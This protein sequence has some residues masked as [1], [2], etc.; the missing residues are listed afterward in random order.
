MNKITSIKIKQNDGTFSDQMPIS[1]L[2]ENI[3]WD[4]THSIIDAIGAVDIN[5][6]GPLQDQ[7]NNK[8]NTTDLSNYVN[9]QLAEDVA[10]W[11]NANVNPVGS[12]V[13]VDK[14]LSISG[15]AADA[16]IVK[17]TFSTKEETEELKEMIF[18]QTTGEIRFKRPE[19]VNGKYSFVSMQKGNVIINGSISVPCLRTGIYGQTVLCASNTPS[20]ARYPKLYQDSLQSFIIDHTIQ[21]NIQLI[22]GSYELAPD[23]E[24]DKCQIALWNKNAGRLYVGPNNSTWT[25]TDYPE[26]IA[27]CAYSGEYN[28]AVFKVTITDLTA[29]QSFPMISFINNNIDTLNNNVNDK[30]ENINDEIKGKDIKFKS[31]NGQSSTLPIVKNDK[32]I[33]INGELISTNNRVTIYGNFDIATNAPTYANHPDWYGTPIDAFIINHDI[34]VQAKLISG[35][36]DLSVSGDTYFDFRNV[37]DGIIEQPVTGTIFKIKAIPEMICVGFKAGIYENAVFEITIKDILK[38]TVIENIQQLKKIITNKIDYEV[39]KI[40]Q[41]QLDQAIT[42]INSETNV[43]DYDAFIFIT[44]PHWYRNK[45]QSPALIKALLEKTPVQTVICGGDIIHSHFATKQGAVNQIKEWENAIKGTGVNEYYC[46]FGNHDDNSNGNPPVEI[47]LGKKELFNLLYGTFAY[48][49]NVHWAPYADWADYYVDHDFSKTR[50]ICLDWTGTQVGEREQWLKNILDINDDYRVLIFHHGVFQYDSANQQ[51]VKNTARFNA[52]T[53]ITNLYPN[54]IK[55]VIQGHVHLDGLFQSSDITQA[56][57]VPYTNGIPYI[58]TSC[59][60]WQENLSSYV[61]TQGTL[62]QQ[63]FDVMVVDYTNLKIHTTRIGRWGWGSS[64]TPIMDR[65]ISIPTD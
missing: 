46:V 31:E 12:A 44:D 6:T 39:P 16:K 53:A 40:F 56:E 1:V 21:I 17:E 3:N 45:K 19:G 49:T 37:N 22:E 29:L 51:I 20:Y 14:T 64:V 34:K 8:V 11:L 33:T 41:Q 10:D 24:S 13:I 47:R 38:N 42:K 50:Y 15:A 52:L 35:S 48:Q 60:T 27:F 54:K 65:E 36:Y 43:A 4:D 63:C 62:D 7:I 58:I 26:M 2:A 23:S 28:N 30:I 61:M 57:T 55:A 9:G 18:T 25:V 32:Y 5:T 59:D